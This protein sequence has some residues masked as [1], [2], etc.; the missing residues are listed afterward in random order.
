M[1]ALGIDVR[2]LLV[3]T[4][5][6]LILF[7]V[8]KKWVFP[9]F[10]KFLESR[11]KKIRESL[12]ASE[13][14]RSELKSFELEKEAERKK[15]AAG[16]QRT[17]EKARADGQ[18]EKEKIIM[19]ARDRGEKIIAEAKIQAALEKEKALKTAQKA[20]VELAMEL[21]KKVLEDVDETQSRLLIK[22]A[23]E[24]AEQVTYETGHSH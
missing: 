2:L 16:A 13:K 5:N 7:F 18:S 3:Q 21:T 20:A 6:F 8:L 10:V 4:I 11:A 17:L 12:E 15:I 22:Q 24:K 9:P 1:E 14:M 19:G 23:L